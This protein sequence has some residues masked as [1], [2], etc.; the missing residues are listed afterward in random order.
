M[1]IEHA[2]A[3]CNITALIDMVANETVLEL[4]I[5]LAECSAGTIENR[6]HIHLFGP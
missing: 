4:S 5:L 6:R 2:L 1:H 3:T